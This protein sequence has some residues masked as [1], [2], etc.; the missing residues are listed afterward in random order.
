MTRSKATEPKGEKA[1]RIYK[2]ILISVILQTVILSYINFYY[3]PNRGNFK[4][5]MFETASTAVKNRSFKLPQGAENVKVSFDGLYAA[6]SLDK[7]LEIVDLDKKEVIK[8]L[9]PSGGEFSY[10]RWLP[11]REMLIYGIKEPEG[12]SSVVRISTYDILPEYNRSYPD[13]KNLPEKS[14]VI[15]IELSPLTNIVYP[16]IKTSNTRARIY[17]FDIMDNLTLIFKTDLTTII[18]ETMY[19]DN[20]I[21]QLEGKGI[22]VRSGKSEK[23]LPIT[24]EGT[25]LL[26]AVDDNDFI[27][28]GDRDDTGKI[29]SIY[30]GM[31]GQKKDE[32]NLAKPVMPVARGDVFI[33]AGGVVY[34]ADRINKQVERLNAQGDFTTAQTGYEGELL[35]VLD[36]YVVSIDGSK[37][38]LQILQQ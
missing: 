6:Y 4:T 33:T 27:Y 30:Y 21:Y 23:A 9:D 12:K 13:I 37:L 29:V 14:Q 7:D 18:K 31:A 8:R 34:T 38:I 5:T 36:N 11:D 2:W 22:I 32:W 28:A 1:K 20:L 26:L 19:A 15:G 17:R 25:G 10:F 24:F 16:M 35:T 3:L